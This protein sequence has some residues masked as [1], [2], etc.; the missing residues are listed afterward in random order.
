MI[1][2]R[3]VKLIGEDGFNRLKNSSVIVFGIGGVGGYVVEALVRSGIGTIAIVDKDDVDETNINRQIYALHSTIGQAKVD[4]AE[5]RIFDI[6]P[7]IKVVK[8]KEF[9]LPENSDFVDLNQFDYVV[10]AIDNVTA[11]VF[12]AKQCSE[13]NIKLISSMGTG[14]K[15]QPEQFRICDIN[16]TSVCPLCR[17]MRSKLKSENVKKLT[18]IF[19]TEQPAKVESRTPASIAFV[20][21]VA[22]FMIAGFVIN[23]LIKPH[24]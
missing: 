22:G 10:D 20:P 11:K 4:V 8:F 1:F 7:E 9:Y 17:V 13:Q 2:D 24:N 14:N 6:N 5:R 12:L 3:T 19:S 15:L 18:V 16:E 23:E 21:S